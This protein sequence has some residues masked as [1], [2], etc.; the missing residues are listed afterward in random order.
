MVPQ[1]LCLLRRRPP[2][3]HAGGRPGPHRGGQK[4]GARHP[5]LGLGGETDHRRPA[6]V[7][8]PGPGH[9]SHPP[10]LRPVR[11]SR[12]GSF[13]GRPG[14]FVASAL[15]APRPPLPAS[16]VVDCVSRFPRGRVCGRGLGGCG[17]SRIG[18]GGGVE[19][20]PG[21]LRQKRHHRPVAY[22][23]PG[24]ALPPLPPRRNVRPPTAGVE[25]DRGLR[26]RRP[27]PV[28]VGAETDLAAGDR[29]LRRA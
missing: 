11:R 9:G 29:G 8:P 26:N 1:G 20:A 5:L 6:V 2:D 17:N 28:H 10:R 4:H 27:P 18:I 13:Y 23:R 3:F 24:G 21:V 15:V 7:Q 16:G 19:D 12:L 14:H 22:L 25:P